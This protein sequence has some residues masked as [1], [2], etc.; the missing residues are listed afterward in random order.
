MSEKHT[1]SLTYPP[2][3]ALNVP[4]GAL[5]RKPHALIAFNILY[6]Y[7]NSSCYVFYKYQMCGTY[8]IDL[9]RYGNIS[10]QSELR[11]AETGY[12][13]FLLSGNH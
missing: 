4:C 13:S 2:A 3:P 9:A 6:E 7:V 5:G 11:S 12:M 8:S 10:H 1:V